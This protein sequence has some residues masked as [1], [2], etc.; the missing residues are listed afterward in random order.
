[1]REGQKTVTPRSQVSKP[2]LV[3]KGGV[4]G[5][6]QDKQNKTPKHSFVLQ[7]ENQAGAILIRLEHAFL[8][9]KV[10]ST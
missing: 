5:T 7:A 3:V 10:E 2:V 6:A 8:S 1:M 9:G 4:G